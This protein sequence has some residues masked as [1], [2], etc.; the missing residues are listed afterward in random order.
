M[1][2]KEVASSIKTH[3]SATQIGM[4]QRCPLQY[5]FRY[6]D[7]KKMPPDSGLILGLCV[8]RG[9]EKNYEHKYRTKKAANRNEV[10]DA[11][12]HQFDDTSGVDFKGLSK[13]TVKDTGYRM[14]G[15]HYDKLA[16]TVQPIE[17]PELQFE[18]EI[19]GVRRKVLGYIDVLARVLSIPVAVVDNKTTRRRFTQFEADLSGQLTTYVYAVRKVFK[20]LAVAGFDIVAEKK[21]EVTEQR[22][23]TQRSPDQ[24]TRFE[25]TVKTIEKAI[26]AGIFY[27]TDNHMTCSWCGF[28]KIC[29]ARAVSA[30][31]A[32]KEA[33]A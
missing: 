24:L 4:F 14:L 31:D 15:V 22:L 30:A 6:V 21:H 19:P 18:I 20:K 2:W 8:H 23:I 10:M 28:N 3:L 1:G 7:G 25:N 32:A 29:H 16:P 9:I 11:F 33:R 12:S 17:K 27:P 5:K 13:G 26:D